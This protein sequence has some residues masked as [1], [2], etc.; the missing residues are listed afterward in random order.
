MGARRG[1][2]ATCPSLPEFEKMTTFAALLGNA[3]KNSL[4]PPMLA[5]HTLKLSLKSRDEINKIFLFAPA[6]RIKVVDYF[7]CLCLCPS[8][9]ISKAPMLVQPMSASSNVEV[10]NQWDVQKLS[11]KYSCVVVF[12]IVRF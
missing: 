4:V 12:L 10:C 3:L 8:G 9:Q 11:A 5:V 7:R 1:K 6:A 2:G